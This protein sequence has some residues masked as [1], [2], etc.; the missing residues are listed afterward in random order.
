MGSLRVV[1]SI[2]VTLPG[3]AAFGSKL[4]PVTVTGKHAEVIDRFA[5]AP[6]SCQP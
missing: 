2:D 3:V 5:T 6:D 1:L 4:A